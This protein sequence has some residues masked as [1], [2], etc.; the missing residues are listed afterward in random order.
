MKDY[1]GEKFNSLIIM[2]LEYKKQKYDKKGIRRGFRYYYK[3]QC[4]CGNEVVVELSNLKTGNTK[5][6][7]C[8]RK[9]IDRKPNQL[10]QY[11]FKDNYGIGIANNTKNK[12]YFDV[13]DYYKIKD[14]AWYENSKGYIINRKKGNMILLHR[15]VLDA[16]SDNF[17]DHI[18]R[19]RLDNRKQNLRFCTPQENSINRNVINKNK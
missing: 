14:L 7:G 13:D 12:F 5:S 3:C 1:I 2:S 18:N 17:V 6:C 15:F 4:D 8:K 19:N 9:N 10:N 11:I 16:E